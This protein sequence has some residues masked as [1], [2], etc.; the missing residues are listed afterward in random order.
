MIRLETIIRAPIEVCFDLARSVEAHQGSTAATGERAV[1][2]VTSGLLGLG[3]EVTWEA[4]HLGVR[5]R[6]R[7]RITELDRPRRFV[8][9]AVAGPFR[10]MRH[11]HEFTS[12]E[13]KTQ[14]TDHFDYELPL[15]AI[16]RLAD[17]IVVRRHLTAFLTARN[18]FLRRAAEAK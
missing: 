2:G 15:G 11:V 7:V 14:M 18:A 3:D 12:V 6:L 5:Q 4:T 17:A 1:C 16:G 10:R 9:E 13:G 8:D